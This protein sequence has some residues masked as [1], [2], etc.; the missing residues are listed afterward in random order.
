MEDIGI[1]L[2]S[3]PNLFAFTLNSPKLKPSIIK[4]KKTNVIVYS[5]QNIDSLH[6][7]LGYFL[8]DLPFQT[9][10]KIDFLY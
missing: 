1:F 8:L 10:K 7:Y 4:H 3:I 2:S 9:R 5:Y 6:D